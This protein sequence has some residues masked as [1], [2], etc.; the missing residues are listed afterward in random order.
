MIAPIWIFSLSTLTRKEAS[1][2][3]RNSQW[4]LASGLTG[5][6]FFVLAN[7]THLFAGA[8]VMA[9]CLQLCVNSFVFA[10]WTKAFRQSKGLKKFVAFFGV[11]V[12]IV[13]AG[14]TLWRVLIPALLR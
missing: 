3:D 2:R 8:D 12:P 7:F 5:F 11:V 6:L 10:V 14:T 1:V 9:G 4:M 13:M